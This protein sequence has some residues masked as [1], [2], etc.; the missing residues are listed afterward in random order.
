MNIPLVDLRRQY[1]TIKKAIETRRQSRQAFWRV[2]IFIKDRIWRLSHR[3]RRLR[4]LFYSVRPVSDMWAI[5]RGTPVIRYYA[6]KF[7]GRYAADIYGTVLEIQD[8]N[9]T[10][11]FGGTV[12]TN[13]EILDIDLTN[14][15]AHI[16]ANLL[17]PHHLPG[18]RYDC[19]IL[20]F[21]LNCIN[22]LGTAIQSVH[23]MLKPGGVL[24]CVVPAL[25]CDA[26]N[27][28]VVGEDVDY[29]RFTT[30]SATYVF[31]RYFTPGTVAVESYG[32]VF[33]ASY[34]LYGLSVEEVNQSKLDY[35]DARFPVIVG[36][37]AQKN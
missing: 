29:W 37:R 3:L 24:L 19:I 27:T 30:A 22:D 9:Y 15:N 8:N 17:D 13:S 25:E 28:V 12:V 5:D 7:L 11:K 32:N 4:F 1:N 2:L 6:E 33:A 14:V 35:Y 16:H 21:V 20:T 34:S 36:I 18:E 31:S 26:A 23:Q 10:K